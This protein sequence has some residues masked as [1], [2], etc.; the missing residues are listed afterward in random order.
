MGS[1]N[2]DLVLDR[3][4]PRAQDIGLEDKDLVREYSGSFKGRLALSG[5]S[6][7]V[8]AALAAM[9]SQVRLSFVVA[10]ST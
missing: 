7:V 8:G 9:I 10:R 4:L 6:S 1:S 2:P 3:V 5:S